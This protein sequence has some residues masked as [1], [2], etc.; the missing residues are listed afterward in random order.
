[1]KRKIALN[2]IMTCGAILFALFNSAEAGN[3][4]DKSISKFHTVD[5]NQISDILTMI[6]NQMRSNYDCIK[7]WQ[8]EVRIISDFIYEG[9]AAERIFKTHTDGEGKCPKAIKEH[10]EYVIE[11]SVDARKEF[12]YA[13]YYSIKPLQYTDI[14][15]GRDLIAKG[16]AGCRIAIVTPEYEFHSTGDTM[17]EGVVTSRRAVKHMRQKGS[18]C[19]NTTPP[20]FDPRELFIPGK[21][22]WETFPQLLQYINEH[23]QVN[24]NRYTLEVEKRTNGSTIEYRV[25]IPGKVSPT[26]YLLMEMIFSG[27]KGFNIVSFETTDS[28]GRLFQKRTWDYSLVNGV[29]LPNKTI[30]QN[31]EH[32]NGNLVYEKKYIFRNSQINHSIPEKTFTYKNLGLKNGDKFVDKIENKEYTY[33][34][35][36]LI[37][38]TEAGK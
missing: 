31:F 10:R 29:Y 11:F 27:E 1:M 24:V 16:I 4:E 38:I 12:L 18:T 22:I 32:K 37:P 5:P 6:S 3:W 9:A 2:I 35:A 34:D 19:D 28:D 14:E 25:Q 8:G 30:E 21:P 20:V 7:T 23:G 36:N 15:T 13:N 33:Q 17:R 26:D